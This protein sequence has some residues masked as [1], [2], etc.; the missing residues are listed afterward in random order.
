[1]KTALDKTSE[2]AGDKI[3]TW[4]ADAN[5]RR[6]GK[7]YSMYIALLARIKDGLTCCIITRDQDRFKNDFQ[8]AT[9][10]NLILKP[11]GENQFEASLNQ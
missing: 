7:S 8:K 9:G 5:R 6:C 10:K 2:I 11:V 4:K 1:M 3:S